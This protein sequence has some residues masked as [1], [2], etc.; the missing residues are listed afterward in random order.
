M[1]NF[2]K[3]NVVRKTKEKYEKACQNLNKTRNAIEGIGYLK[4]FFNI[5]GSKKNSH[6][7]CY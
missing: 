1:K 3:K 4:K 5:L 6:Y 7:R 2:I